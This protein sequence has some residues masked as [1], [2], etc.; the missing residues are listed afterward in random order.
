MWVGLD[1]FALILIIATAS[2]TVLLTFVIL[3]ML[4]CSQPVRRIVLARAALMLSLLMLPMTESNPLPRSKILSW[5][6]RLEERWVP[7]SIAVAETAVG[8]EGERPEPPRTGLPDCKPSASQSSS[9]LSGPA[10]R[11]PRWGSEQG[12]RRL[13]AL[14]YLA[15]VSAGLAWFLVGIWGVR[16]L[17]RGSRD[18]ADATRALFSELIEQTEAKLPLASLRVSERIKRPVVAG[19]FQPRILIPPEY[20]EPSFDP[21]SLRIML[22]HELAHADQA[23]ARFGAAASLAQTFWFFHPFLWWLRSQL[24]LD[25]EF[26][27]DQRAARIL[28]SPAGYAT[29]LVALATAS[30]GRLPSPP[31]FDTVPLLADR[32]GA[33][34]AES[35]LSQRVLM[36]LHCPFPLEIQ[37]PRSWVLGAPPL[38]L[39]LAIL[40]S[41]LAQW[42]LAPFSS[43]AALPPATYQPAKNFR[44]SQFVAIPRVSRADGRRLPYV[45]PLLLP[46]RFELKT[47]IVAS[48]K[49]LQQIRLAGLPL[50]HI[51]DPARK[52]G[53]VATDDVITTGHPVIIHRRGNHLEVYVDE[54]PVLLEPSD[55]P[56]EWLSIEPAPDES[57]I[58]RNLVVTW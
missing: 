33:G 17:I 46:Q 15:G 37:P 31:L 18:P 40:I 58:L 7:R 22:V 50:G 3:A 26:L 36:L 56:S 57:A 45:L 49:A 2:T 38:V 1:W 11:G 12:A 14:L 47:E 29:R 13:V 23:D 44:V 28:G 4:L 27:A 53:Y 8:A 25:Q 24:L 32:R 6:P 19:F 42:L 48:A 10:S 9:E 41:T 30:P 5:L 35:P 34:R 54:T 43:A 20:D 16:R 39:V 52:P 55:Q 51:S 21:T